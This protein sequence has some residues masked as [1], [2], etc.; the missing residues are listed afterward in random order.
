MEEGLGVMV[1]DGLTVTDGK[2]VNVKEGADVVHA[3]SEIISKPICT[4]V[5]MFQY[6]GISLFEVLIDLR[7]PTID[8]S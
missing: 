6:F 1:A 8:T 2:A 5:I 3:T 4:L 7:R